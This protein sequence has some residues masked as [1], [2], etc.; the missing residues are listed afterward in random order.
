MPPD[1]PHKGNS[2]GNAGGREVIFE[3]H[4]VGI[5]IKV[6][7]VDVET[8]LEVSVVGP[9]SAARSELERVAVNKLRYMLARQKAG[10]GKDEPDPEGG[11]GGGILV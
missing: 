9:S 7:A 5:S 4:P 10:D 3:Y 11:T 1:G 6:T 8:G 2:G